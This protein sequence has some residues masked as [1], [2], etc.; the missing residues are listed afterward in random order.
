M[1]KTPLKQSAIDA[2]MTAF[3]ADVLESIKQAKRDEAAR[4]HTASDIAKYKIRG[5]H[6]GTVK[7]DVKQASKIIAT[8]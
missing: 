8:N 2:E 5:R 7:S 4:R 1:T 6:V 3:A